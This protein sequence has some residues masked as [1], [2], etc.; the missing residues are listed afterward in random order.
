MAIALRAPLASKQYGHEALLAS[1]ISEACLSVMPSDPSFFNVDNVRVVKILGSGLSSSK[2]VKGMVFGREPE[3]AIKQAKK[4][5]VAV[6]TCGIDIS[7]TETKGTVLLKN[8][9]ELLSF[10]RGEEIQMEKVRRCI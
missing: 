5:K 6:Y 4:A 1:L 10:S 2:V 9:E 8:S 7:Q 3:G